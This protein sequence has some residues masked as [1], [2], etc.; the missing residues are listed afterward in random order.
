MQRQPAI[1]K[2]VRE[3]RVAI[4]H[5]GKGVCVI[6]GNGVEKG[7]NGCLARWRLR[8]NGGN[9]LKNYQTDHGDESAA[10]RKPGS[11]GFHVSSIVLATDYTSAIEFQLL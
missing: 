8:Q 7:F 5:L 6:F 2:G 4:Q 11:D 1:I 9:I 10:A 3:V